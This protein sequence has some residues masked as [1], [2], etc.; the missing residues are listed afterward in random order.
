VSW[1]C[2]HVCGRV[3]TGAGAGVGVGVDV[4]VGVGAGAGAGEPFILPKKR[5]IR[6][7]YPCI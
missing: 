3:C 5:C 7:T 4:D 6:L 1:V 2:V